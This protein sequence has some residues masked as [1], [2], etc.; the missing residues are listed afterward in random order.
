MIRPLRLPPKPDELAGRFPPPP[1]GPLDPSPGTRQGIINEK[2]DL[3]CPQSM[4]AISAASTNRWRSK[5]FAV[6]SL[7]GDFLRL[8][9]EFRRVA[10]H[11]VCPPRAHGADF[12]RIPRSYFPGPLLLSSQIRFTANFPS[13]AKRASMMRRRLLVT[14]GFLYMVNS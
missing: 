2:G 11:P 3:S 14:G 6:S 5:V 10:A 9:A 4:F 1:A 13:K 7:R 12:L 8:D